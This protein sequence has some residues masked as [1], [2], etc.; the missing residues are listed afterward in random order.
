MKRLLT[1]TAICL[2]LYLFAQG[3]GS[4]SH[5]QP[6]FANDSAAGGQTPEQIALSAAVHRWVYSDLTN[7]A[8]VTNWIDRIAGSVWT[9]GAIANRATNSSSGV[10]FDSSHYLTNNWQS[11]PSNVAFGFIVNIVD[12]D[13]GGTVHP[14][15]LFDNGPSEGTTYGYRFLFGGEQ[16]QVW[17][18]NAGYDLTVGPYPIVGTKHTMLFDQ[19]H[20]A[21]NNDVYFWT[22]N[23][24]SK[25]LT[26]GGSWATTAGIY[27]YWLGQNRFRNSGPKMF[28]NELWIWTNV[29]GSQLTTSVR[30]N[31]HYYATN[32]YGFT[33]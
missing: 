2:P 11:F 20:I 4:F 31:W 14:A 21:G 30:S 9:N 15:L 18:A 8:P 7:N 17:L 13:D 27:P 12:P 22:N 3:F 26:G 6:F 5:D 23:V 1:L 10:F 33:P 19:A 32:T 24:M 25:T 28:I 29:V 16:L